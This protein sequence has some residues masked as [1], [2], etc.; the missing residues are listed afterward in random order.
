MGD[1]VV[2][3]RTSYRFHKTSGLG[4]LSEAV[5]SG[6]TEQIEEILSMEF[7][8]VQVEDATGTEREKWLIKQILKGYEQI[9]QAQTVEQAFTAM[10]QFRF[11]CTVRRGPSGIESINTLAEK[12]LRKKE[13]IEAD[14]EQYPGRPIIIRRNN[15]AM[16][17]FNGDTGLLWNDVDGKL[18]AWFRRADNTLYPL[19]PTR[20]PEHD[21]A[22][23]ITIHKAQGSEFEEVLLLLPEEENR[24]LSRELIYTGITRA[25]KQLIL[26]SNRVILLN[27]IK[28]RT[29]RHSGLAE[30]LWPT[31]DVTTKKI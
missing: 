31:Q 5:N 6:D 22:Y 2:L 8:D 25:R 23:A 21:T 24:I 20:L 7:S 11:L 29:C 27:A 15:Y 19:T 14:T 13:R 10:E 26:C 9:F 16:Q 3:L 12:T 17:L 30:K 1:S 18:K 28:K 4:K